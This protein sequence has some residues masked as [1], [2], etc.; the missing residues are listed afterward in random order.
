MFITS[1]YS[2]I[3]KGRVWDQSRGMARPLR[4]DHAGGW[5]HVTGRGNER[6][7][8][9]RADRDRL[10]FLE[11]LGEMVARFRLRC[12]AFVLME[13]HYHLLLELTEPNL[14]RALQWL[15]L[16]YSL[17][18]NRRHDRSGHL[19]QGRFKSIVVEPAA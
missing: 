17:W 9:Y 4:I 5:Y 6:R 11:L 3:D 13:N 1:E 15:N 10:H 7:A 12:H 2:T 18:F 19:F 14:S 8:I 16:S